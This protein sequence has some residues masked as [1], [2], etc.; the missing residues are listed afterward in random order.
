MNELTERSSYYI[1]YKDIAK[2]KARDYYNKNK[3]KI[4]KVSKRK[5]QKHEY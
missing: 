1:R 4:K 2:Q 3:E 5:M